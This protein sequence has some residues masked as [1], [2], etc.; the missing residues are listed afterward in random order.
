M[1]QLCCL[2]QRIIH[3]MSSGGQHLL[4][5]MDDLQYADPLAIELFE[6]FLFNSHEFARNIQS[7]GSNVPVFVGT[8]RDNEV[9]DTNHL[10][11]FLSSMR[12]SSYC[13]RLMEIHLKICYS[14]PRTK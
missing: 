13:V 10:P 12:E 5:F 7:L 6:S 1:N 14:R 3:A 9:N 8:Y 11:S 2:F 4:I